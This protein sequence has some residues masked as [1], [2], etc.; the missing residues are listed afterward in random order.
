VKT[1]VMIPTYNERENI[2][3]LVSA[4]LEL[5]NDIKVVVVD[6]NSPDGTGQIADELARGHPNRIYVIHRN[7]RGRGTAGIAGFR[8]ALTLDVDYI[9]EM[10]A[11]FA[12]DPKYIPVFLR[13]VKNY[14]IVIGS[15]FIKGGK[16]IRNPIRKLISNGAN[17][18]AQ[19]LLGRHIK[20]WCGGYK[21]YRRAALDS[22]NFDHFYSKGYSI[23]METLWRL[24]S[25]GFTYEEIPIKFTDKRGVE[26]KFSVKEVVGYL[27]TVFRLKVG[28]GKS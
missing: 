26:S 10:D 22:L 11:D 23:G 12:H 15:R 28:S 7:A 3:K 27:I 18:Y 24:A 5:S 21:C 19:L 9:I 13:E 20:D 1:A 25:K 8:Y 4:I 14:D 16:S 17:L 2:R 6:D